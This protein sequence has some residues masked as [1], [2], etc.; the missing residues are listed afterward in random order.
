MAVDIKQVFIFYT[1]YTLYTG[2]DTPNQPCQFTPTWTF[3]NVCVYIAAVPDKKPKTTVIIWLGVKPMKPFLSED[4]R[5]VLFDSNII[6]CPIYKGA[7]RAEA[8]EIFV[9]VR[10]I[11]R[12]INHFLKLKDHALDER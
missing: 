6:F 9:L 3:E 11:W 8:Q 5:P 2:K 10:L 12:S 4:K 7:S 1:I